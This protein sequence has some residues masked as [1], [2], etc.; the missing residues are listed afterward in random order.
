M[1]EQKDEAYYNAL[2][3]R[4]KEYKDWKSKQPLKGVGDVVEKVL[5]KTGVSRIAKFILGDDCGCDQRRDT[6]NKLFPFKNPKCLN[7]D[8]YDFL[9]L[10]FQKTRHQITHDEQKKILNIYN[11]V[12]STKYKTSNCGGCVKWKLQEL[13]LLY[14]EYNPTKN[15]N[16][17]I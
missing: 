15:D 10:W 11:R 17:I 12:F 13:N 14:L 6:L 9:H 3:K 8:E 7:E 1:S 5:E 4:T 16:D 2:D